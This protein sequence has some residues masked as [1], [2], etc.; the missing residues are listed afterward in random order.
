MVQTCAVHLISIGSL[1]FYDTNSDSRNLFNFNSVWNGF[2]HLA[3]FQKCLQSVSR[4]LIRGES[5]NPFYNQYS[6]QRIDSRKIKCAT[7]YLNG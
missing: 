6:H 5:W 7:H 4:P 3:T 1:K 2:Y